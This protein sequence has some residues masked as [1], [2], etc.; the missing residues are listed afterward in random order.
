MAIVSNIY[1]Y[2]VERNFNVADHLYVDHYKY[3][4]D[5]RSKFEEK[6]PDHNVRVIGNGSRGYVC[7]WQ[8]D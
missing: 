3:T 1:K 5:L 4:T 6:K 2:Y 8:T 7:N